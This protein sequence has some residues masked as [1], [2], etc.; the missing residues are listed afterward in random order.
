MTETAVFGPGGYR[1][2]RGPFQYS[3][4]VAAEPGYVIERVRFANPVP[5]E[6]GFRRIEAY[7]DTA[8]RPYTSFCACELRSPAPFTD[9]EFIDFNRIYVGTLERWGIFKD[10]E[11]PV[12]RSNVCPKIQPPAE[13]CFEAFCHTVTSSPSTFREIPKSFV[14]A[15]SGEAQESPGPYREKTIRY[16]ETSAEAMRE[17]AI[18]VLGQ[19]ESRMSALGFGWSDATTTQVYT[20]HDLYPFLADE[21]VSR[22]ATK[23]GLTWFFANPPVQGLEYEMDLRG[24]PVERVI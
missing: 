13:P 24:I 17:K 22:G 15:G 2:I 19:M 3:G 14:I 9:Q 1:Y 21:I 6:E 11:N 5:V 23:G 4:G 18:F 7:L 16:G 20:V 8:N 12:A 10:D